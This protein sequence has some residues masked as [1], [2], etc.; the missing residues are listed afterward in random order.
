MIV[1]LA[2]FN[3]VTIVVNESPKNN[4][5]DQQNFFANTYF[6][7][8]GE[9]I[10][11]CS[12]LLTFNRLP[13]KKSHSDEEFDMRDDEESKNNAMNLEYK[14]ENIDSYSENEY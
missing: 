13:K 5:S 1:H 10:Y 14:Y 9:L 8:E 11:A 3:F 7:H 4:L 12:Y 2:L 6:V